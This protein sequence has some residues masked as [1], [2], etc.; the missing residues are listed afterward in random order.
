MD[1]STYLP[2]KIMTHSSATLY[3]RVRMLHNSV[4]FTDE[5]SSKQLD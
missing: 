2:E 5:S 1:L 4:A 3:G